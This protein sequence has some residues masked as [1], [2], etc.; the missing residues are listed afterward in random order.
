MQPNDGRVVSNFILQALANEP[1]TV[2]GRGDQTRSF[3]YVTDL[4]DALVLLMSTRPD[5]VGPV[6]LGNPREHTILELAQTTIALTGSRSRIELAPLPQDDPAQRRPDISLAERELGW[7]PQVPLETGLERTILYFD[8]LLTAGRGAA[9]PLEEP[10]GP[11]A[12]AR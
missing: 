8:R 9:V 10:A 11:L 3:C 2:Y 4:I 1:I 7:R 6:N 12:A 5:F